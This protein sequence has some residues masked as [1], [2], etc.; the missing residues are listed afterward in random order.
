[1]SKRFTMVFEGDIRSFPGN[2]LKTETPFGVPY[3]VA[4]G[5]LVEQLNDLQ[6]SLTP[7]PTP[8]MPSTPEGWKL[9][10]EDPDNIMWCAGRD[11]DIHPGDSY[12][13][14]WRAMY[15]N[16]PEPPVPPGADTYPNAEPP[17]WLWFGEVDHKAVVTFGRWPKHGAKWRYK[18]AEIQP[19][20]HDHPTPS[21]ATNADAW[22]DISTAP[23]NGTKVL[24]RFNPPFNDTLQDGVVTGMWTGDSWWLSSI[25]ASCTALKE[26]SAWCAIP[27]KEGNT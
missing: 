21:A 8:N 9:V 12:S 6:D 15:E 14:V 7:A 3:T 25:W 22:Q 1:M 16:A 2:P 17:E 27:R 4:D 5:D 24:L 19:T 23:K 20:E 11:A 13:K 10:P 18:L 26:P